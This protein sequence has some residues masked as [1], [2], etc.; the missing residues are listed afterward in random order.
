VGALNFFLPE[1]ISA[2]KR[3][4][5]MSC[6]A[7]LARMSGGALRPMQ[8]WDGRSP[9]L[10]QS[11]QPHGLVVTPRY[12]TAS[13]RRERDTLYWPGVPAETL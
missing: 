7:A 1:M 12:G 2:T 8:F 6:F 10:W 13:I 11:P 5:A 4:S 3:S 9:S